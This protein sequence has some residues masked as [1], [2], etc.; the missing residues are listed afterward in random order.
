MEQDFKILF[1]EDAD[2]GEGLITFELSRAP[3]PV[4]VKQVQDRAAFLQALEEFGPHLILTD[5]RLPSFDGLTA[6]ALARE[7]CPE[8]PFIF[9]SEVLSE[10]LGRSGA[11][12]F[13]PEIDGML[14]HLAAGSLMVFLAPD[15]R[16]LEFNHGAQRLTGWQRGEVLGK[17]AVDLLIPGEQRQLAKA[18]LSEIMAGKPAESLDLPLQFRDG[19]QELFRLEVSLLRDAQDR[20]LGILLVGHKVAEPHRKPKLAQSKPK[21]TAPLIRRS[22]GCC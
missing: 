15:G 16:I 14:A 10:E 22:I 5:Y 12:Q 1:L 21:P 3:R 2:R 7:V 11:A 19:S 13:G 8:V 20:P 17:D 9:V 4:A 18:K 6:L